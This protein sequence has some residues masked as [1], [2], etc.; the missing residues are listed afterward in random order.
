MAGAY[1]MRGAAAHGGLKTFGKGW[2]AGIRLESVGGKDVAGTL[3]IGF[4]TTDQ[5]PKRIRG[6][7]IPKICFV[8]GRVDCARDIE[9]FF[10]GR[11]LIIRAPFHRE[12]PPVLRKCTRQV[13]FIESSKSFIQSRFLRTSR[14]FA[15]S[16]GP[17]MPSFSIRSIKRA[18]RP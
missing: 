2:R 18:A 11:I 10:A 9:A 17:T 7:L 8:E 5:S 3:G 13:Y 12:S 14:G 15:P 16:G 6:R 4:R 1:G